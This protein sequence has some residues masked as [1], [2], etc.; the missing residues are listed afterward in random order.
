MILAVLALK[1]FSF[2]NY[3]L[4]PRKKTNFI[5]I[6][7]NASKAHARVSADENFET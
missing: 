3:I 4:P 7:K 6:L 5:D 1:L 2:Q